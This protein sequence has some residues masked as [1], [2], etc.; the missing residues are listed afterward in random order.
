MVPSDVPVTVTDASAAGVVAPLSGRISTRP[1]TTP[2]DGFC[3]RTAAGRRQSSVKRAP[4]A[5]KDKGDA[6]S[7]R[8]MIVAS[9]QRGQSRLNS[10][11]PKGRDP[12]IQTTLPPLIPSD[13]TP[14]GR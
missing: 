8:Q 5:A 13:L 12:S 7:G 1:V 4:T 10:R 14:N 11:S 6:G 2:V 3:P 9:D